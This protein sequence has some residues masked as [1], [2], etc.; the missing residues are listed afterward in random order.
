MRCGLR[1]GQTEWKLLCGTH[2]LFKLWR[3]T[4]ATAL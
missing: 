3:T 4:T 2:N 1:A